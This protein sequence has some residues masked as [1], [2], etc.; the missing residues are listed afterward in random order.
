MAE[1][2]DISEALRERVHELE[3]RMVIEQAKGMIAARHHIGLQ[4]AFE[5][6][7]RVARSNHMSL[8]QLAAGVVSEPGTPLEIVREL[9]DA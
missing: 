1:V 6:M 5:A 9:Y 2:E 8:H 3:S 4:A 7:R